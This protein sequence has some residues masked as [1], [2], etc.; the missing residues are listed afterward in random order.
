MSK[1]GLAF[2]TILLMGALFL[3]PSATYSLYT[4][5]DKAKPA[6]LEFSPTRLIVK[7]TPEADKKVS[8]GKVQGKITTGLAPLD[9]LNLKFEV[10]KQERLFKEFK[11]TALKL[12]KFSSVYILEV[13]EGTDLKRMK[14]EYESL[15]EVEY[16]ELD[17][18]LEL[19]EEPDDPLFPHQWY[20]NNLGAAQNDSQ[21]YY[22]I[23]RDAG[24]ALVM[25][26]G[27]EDADIDALEAFERDHET[28]IPLVGIIDTGVDLDH[29]DLEDNVWTNPGEIPNNEV[30]DDHNGFVDDFYGWDF[31]G[32]TL[33]PIVEDN[34]PTDTY[35][36]GTHCAG[37]AAATRDNQK[38]VSG[39][40]S[41]CK[42]M[43]IKMF[44][45]YLGGTFLSLGAKSIIY[46]ADM[47]CDVINMSWGGPFPSKIVEDALDYAIYKGVLPVAAAG[48]SGAEDYFYPASL[49]QVFTVGA[50]N[51]S[52]V[53]T[54]FST[55]G[56]QI[57]VVAP[58]RDILSLRADST[59]M[60]ADMGFPL[61]H[62]IDEKYY[63]ADGTSMASPCVVG[64]A[65]YILAASP[66]ISKD[67]V[68]EIIQQSADDM[69]YP[70]GGDSL[71][72]PGWDIYSGYGR[73]N[74]NSALELLSGRLAEIDYP[75][76]NAIVSGDVAIIGTASGD[77]FE[78]Y[79]L[80]Y[81]EG[82]SPE[83]WTEITSSVLPVS[84]DTLGIWNSA[85]L[86]GLYTI[87]LTVGDQNQ[88]AV[89]VVADNGIYVEITSPTDGDTILGYAEI[90]GN[91]VMPDF[92]HYTLEYGYGELPSM[93]L[94]ITTSTKMVAD[95][96]LGTWGTWLLPYFEEMY[97][98]F[99]LTVVTNA[100]DTCADTVVVFVKSVAS[101]KW[102]QELSASGSL[103]P[104]VGDIDGDGYDEVVLGVGGPS[105]GSLTGGIKVFSHEGEPEDGWPKDTLKNM[106][107]SPA[108]GDLDEDG[109]DDII[110]CSEQD[111]V[112]AYL[113][114]SDDWVGSASTGGNLNWSLSTPLL[115]DLENDGHLEVLTV[116]DDGTVYAW[117]NDGQSVIPGNNGIFAWTYVD[118]RSSGFPCLAVA[119]LDI[120]GENEVIAAVANGNCI[121]GQTWAEGGIYIWDIL[122]NQLLEPE[123]YPDQF[124][125]VYG[126]AIA[127]IDDNEDLEIITF[128][129][130][131]S[132]ATLSAFK[133]DG[134]QPP[135]YPVILEDLDCQWYGNHPAIGDV[136]GDGILEIAV[137][138]WLIGE[139]RVY[140]WHQDGTPLG[141]VDSKG[142]LV[143]M[144]SPDAERKRA[145][146]SS[147]GHNTTEV[148]TKIR[149]MS[150][151]ELTAFISTYDDPVF[152]SVPETFGSPV[153][154]D[155]NGDGNAD[156][157]ARA[158]YFL[159]I[160]LERVYAWDCSGD[161]LPGWPLYASSEATFV[162]IS[163][164]TPVIVDMDKDWNF[165][166]VIVTDYNI[167]VTPR[168][169]CW[170]FDTYYDPTRWPK[171]MH[172]KWNTG[173]YNDPP[174][175]F[176]LLFPPN[177]ARTPRVVPFDWETASDPNPSDQVRYDLWVSTSYSFPPGSTTIDAN[178][179]VSEHNKTLD[180]GTYYWKVKAKD[181]HGAERWS[182]QIRY[183]MVTGIPSE[184]LDPP[185]GYGS[186]DVEYVVFLINYLYTSGPAPHPLESADA[187]CD[188]VVDV[189]D[190]VYLINYLFM[191]GSPP[192]C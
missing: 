88:D 145:V 176:S 30:D 20:L 86:V 190:I 72:S 143:S 69:I 64:V 5:K 89:H 82:F 33:D 42:I 144:K 169:V 141:S 147:L 74:L 61:T 78:N 26:F 121:A 111:G 129:A 168:L 80:E 31:A 101:V 93:W 67:S 36:H 189:A 77:S 157:V 98:S 151:E 23:D 59:D 175:P 37:I 133:K 179:V 76:E 83:E 127:N 41:P 102:V 122:G 51:D 136:D 32:S 108:L 87:R 152:A 90:Y 171:Y 53:V 2:V 70:F 63:L 73:V 188:E 158:G 100:A 27:I 85:G 160:G 52:D 57:E 167:Y 9:S 174:G 38:G 47:G 96:I 162:T 17:Y 116:N 159:G 68:K 1:R 48:N 24:H 92:S 125:C 12:D 58:G 166:M 172:D 132:D 6:E 79:V 146:L 128:G 18:K 25:K 185:P 56:E 120:D 71:Y 45:D 97:Y 62:I 113:S 149:S 184:P 66:G 16:V 29:E 19:F 109:I 81:G 123:D 95:D 54:W 105:G 104:A 134:T 55:Y 148:V 118:S 165:E 39:I 181:N 8:L 115:A 11:E 150:R 112:H 140:A 131:T 186:I 3:G 192:G 155:V 110:I 191:G 138:A 4:G 135:N 161:L 43:A 154:A 170:E 114:S 35:G 173:I 60:Y 84:N 164:Y 10:T 137:T 130:D 99:R 44:P 50:S 40:T 106:M 75:F 177:K 119:D 103:S 46:A 22:G 183:F 28:T 34:D 178:L 107:S 139:A 187:N 126:V 15:P 14:G 153:L 7:L 124:T 182:S 142:P 65:A 180:Y 156:I 21:G 49:P 94:P 13:P 91:T 117:R 163:P